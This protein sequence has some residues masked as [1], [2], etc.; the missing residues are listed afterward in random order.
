MNEEMKQAVAE[1]KTANE[2][3]DAML[4]LNEK[5]IVILE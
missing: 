1:L 4:V 5:T 2:K 3:L